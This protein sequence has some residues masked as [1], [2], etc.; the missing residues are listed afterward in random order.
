M[1]FMTRGSEKLP[2]DF[3]LLGREKALE[4]MSAILMRD[5]ANSIILVGPGGVGRSAVCF[6]LQAL[7]SDP[8]A[9][10]DI[11]SKRLFWLETDELFSSGDNE[12]I[13]AN[14]QKILE[15]HKRTTDSVL[16]VDDSRDFIEACRNHNCTHFI[17]SLN[18]YVKLG[19][20]QIIF[21]C[22]DED[23]DM[24]IKCHSDMTEYYTMMDLTE[25]TPDIL[26]TIV[27]GISDSLVHSHGIKI[28]EAAI[29]TSIELTTKYR[30]RDMGLSRA[31]PERSV[32]LLDR[33]LAKFRLNAHKRH[34]LVQDLLA[35]KV[36]ESDE[37]IIKLD[38]EFAD[39]QK[40]IK[41]LFKLQR[42]G[43]NAIMD[44]EDELKKVQEH[45]EEMRKKGEA[46]EETGRITAFAQMAQNGG[47]ESEKVTELKAK[48]QKFQEIVDANREK[49]DAITAS[50]NDQLHLT[51][52]NVMAE[53]S[54]ISGIAANKL[55]QD[56][57]EK[58][59]S[60]QS[61]MN[62]RIFG[63][64]E[65]VRRLSDAVKVARIGRRNKN[66]PQA[67]FM[68]LGPSG[69]GKTEIAKVLAAC[70][71]DDESALTRFDMSEYMEKH[72][73]AKLIG[74]PP[75]Y[76]GFE[77]GGI[78][79]NAMRKNPNRILLFD[80]IEKAHPD[81]FNI[82]LQVLSDG[83]LTD[84]VGRTIS[85][86]DAII[87]M[88]TNIGQPHFLNKDLTVEEMESLANKDLDGTYRSE[89]L[90][91]FAGRENIL[92]FK[93]LELDSIEKIVQREIN[94]MDV[95][96]MDQGLNIWIDPTDLKAFC[97]DHYNPVIGARGLPGYIQ[98]NLEPEITNTI[99]NHPDFHGTFKVG[100]DKKTKKFTY[101]LIEDENATRS[102]A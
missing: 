86:S 13:N 48:I 7:K 91:R 44:L 45:E 22:R 37:R 31:Q 32:T 3:K 93:R 64:D 85:F 75:G 69:V 79:T 65:A 94:S 58:L 55:N 99:L 33:S 17:N 40:E 2:K 68:F 87:I 11:V 1:D 76:E 98:A 5:R 57:R 89:F 60:L 30:T 46:S 88:T 96:Y 66:Q 36:P 6:G 16:I 82:F 74:A 95:A 62:K 73:V 39:T 19:Y 9:P 26:P 43:E 29:S 100:Y 54:A 10:F 83:R 50:I 47:I 77:V 59:K 34:P 27:K 42:D 90:N 35:Q 4:E 49:F 23:L 51:K 63:Q 70:L 92:C 81:V 15:I 101:E 67:S 41:R 21:E 52:E 24:V 12:K 18:S 38:A 8:N 71:L 61:D 14:F 20:M 80:E 56:E 25:P 84:N 78:L 28:D 102:A 53:F 72:A 97:A